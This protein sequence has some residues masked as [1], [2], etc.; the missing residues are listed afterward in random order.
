MTRAILIIL[1][2]LI[3]LSLH[4]R[5]EGCVRDSIGD[6]VVGAA[7]SLLHPQDSLLVDAVSTDDEGKFRLSADS[8]CNDYILLVSCL[9]FK[10]YENTVQNN[11]N[12][13][14]VLDIQSQL[15]LD[16]LKVVASKPTVKRGLG[17]FSIRPNSYVSLVSNSFELIGIMPMIERQS[18]GFSIIGGSEATIYLNGRKPLMDKLQIMR[19][20]QS[21]PA[22]NIKEI[23]VVQSSGASQ[24]GSII[25]VIMDRPD[26][27]ILGSVNAS[28][29]VADNTYGGSG[30][31]A[32][33]YT[34][35]RL[36]LHVDMSGGGSNSTSKNRSETDFLDD[37]ISESRYNKSNSNGGNITPALSAQYDLN[38]NSYVGA[39]VMVRKNYN[40]SSNNSDISTM[41]PDGSV[42]DIYSGNKSYETKHPPQ[43]AAVGTYHLN[44][45]K[46]GSSYI[47]AVAD[48]YRDSG[49]S[50]TDWWGLSSG[51][52]SEYFGE[53]TSIYGIKADME[54]HFSSTAK[55]D[56]GYH[57]MSSS[58]HNTSDNNNFLRT[59]DY[60]YDEYLHKA[61]VNF[62]HQPI[63]W[64]QYSL[65]LRMENIT[66]H[67]DQ[68]VNGQKSKNNNFDLMPEAEIDFFPARA[69]QQIHLAYK[70][71]IERPSFHQMNPVETWTSPTTY[72][73]GNPYLKTSKT[74]V[75]SLFYCWQ[76]SL[77]SHVLFNKS[78]SLVSDYIESPEP[79]IVKTTYANTGKFLL[80]RI[81][82][83]FQKMLFKRWSLS[84]R[85]T[86]QYRYD[87]GGVASPHTKVLGWAWGL[88]INNYIIISPKHGITASLNYSLTSPSRSTFYSYRWSN[89]ASA[90]INKQF[91]DSW[92]LSLS[93]INIIPPSRIT[94][95]DTPSLHYWSKTLTNPFSMSLSA[96]YTFGKN[97][98]RKA[99]TST[100]S[101][102]DDR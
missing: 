83:G 45:D 46:T 75:L 13:E 27:G 18:D 44:L 52:Y 77:Y 36:A 76:N 54:K 40:S 93:A 12:N 4:A 7:V 84:A 90:S 102:L 94:I 33:N 19:Y 68:R 24:R 78:N 21:I 79:G 72:S 100:S 32:I 39:Y 25:N 81:T 60:R 5:I 64:I 63:K 59:N 55:F 1:T 43:V 34:H 8:V 98:L 50:Q 42:S 57:Y 96:S 53:K 80:T 3:S 101:S 97:T 71:A 26:E 14:I 62:L 65:G 95:M 86:A 41:L 87:D 48:Y 30:A 10:D 56:A 61:Y 11:S 23:I 31:A 74:H 51:D 2:A 82:L 58:I 99:K 20:L 91:G 85:T 35:N 16:E 89:D 70:L 66:Q 28:V 6:P 15:L 22:Q 29:R 9:G 73:C 92:R 37:G 67:I 38:A 17:N 47:E 49:R 69:S 88:G